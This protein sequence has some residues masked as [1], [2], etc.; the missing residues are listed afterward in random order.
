MKPGIGARKIYRAQT[1][2][3]ASRKRDRDQ[4]ATRR[5]HKKAVQ[6][7]PPP[8]KQTRARWR[9]EFEAHIER[10]RIM[11]IIDELEWAPSRFGAGRK[12]KTQ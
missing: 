3:L 10:Q 6:K 5:E 7:L 12:A 11:G 9:K 1:D 2:A 8:S 4:A